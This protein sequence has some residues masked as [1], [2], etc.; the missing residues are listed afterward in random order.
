MC[1]GSQDALII[2]AVITLAHSLGMSTIAEG[3]GTPAQ[4]TALR[5]SRCDSIQGYLLA[6]PTSGMHIPAM[7]AAARGVAATPAA[8]SPHPR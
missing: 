6:R 8:P 5:L 2:D 1:T 4:P 7:L 3:V